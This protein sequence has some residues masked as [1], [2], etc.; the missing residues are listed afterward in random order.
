MATQ[1]N[2]SGLA[3]RGPTPY[4]TS[5]HHSDTT[6]ARLR[7]RISILRRRDESPVS[8]RT[9]AQQCVR[10]TQPSSR[11]PRATVLHGEASPTDSAND[12]AVQEACFDGWRIIRMQIW[13]SRGYGQPAASPPPNFWPSWLPP[14]RIRRRRR[15]SAARARAPLSPAWIHPSWGCSTHE[16][17]ATSS[18]HLI[19]SCTT[20]SS[21]TRH[22]LSPYPSRESLH[23]PGGPSSDG[24]F[25]ML[26]LHRRYCAPRVCDRAPVSATT[27]R[28]RRGGAGSQCTSQQ[29]VAS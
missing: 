17:S 22:T 7:H 21:P 10:A 25:G 1:M 4:A 13:L 19:H 16:R 29:A 23:P 14:P 18:P 6:L 5:E 26:A 3:R 27:T 9:T 24:H 28:S 8:A 2:V 12:P 11:T 15:V 20:T